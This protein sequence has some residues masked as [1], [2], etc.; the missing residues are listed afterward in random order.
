MTCH[1]LRGTPPDRRQP[2][3]NNVTRKKN[4]KSFKKYR[5]G[6]RNKNAWQAV[7][8]CHLLGAKLSGNRMP[9]YGKS[10]RIFGIPVGSIM[11]WQW[12]DR[13]YAE[14]IGW[15]SKS[16]IMKFSIIAGYL[17]S[18]S[19][20]IKML[21]SLNL[22]QKQSVPKSQLRRLHRK[23]HNKQRSLRNQQNLY[24]QSRKLVHLSC[25]LCI[26]SIN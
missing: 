18:H 23:R 22:C 11:W 4:V 16:A 20:V 21:T 1:T 2:A 17:E 15:T 13:E 8:C 24:W 14:K 10:A 6:E 12:K 26:D 5:W 3:S 25:Q 19:H 7:P 9:N